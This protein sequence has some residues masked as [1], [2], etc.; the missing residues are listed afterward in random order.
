MMYISYVLQGGSFRM[1]RK[2][3]SFCPGI[4]LSHARKKAG[5]RMLPVPALPRM[6]CILFDFRHYSV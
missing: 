6:G 2:T 5:N 4:F 1:Q 3:L